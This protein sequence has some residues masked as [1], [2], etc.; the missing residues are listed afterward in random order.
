MNRRHFLKTTGIITVTLASGIG[1]YLS[2][3]PLKRKY[4][5]ENSLDAF[6]KKESILILNLK[7]MFDHSFKNNVKSLKPEMLL[8]TLKN[9]G[10]I[11]KDNQ[12]NIAKIKILAK[13]EPL[14]KYNGFYYSKTELELYSLA[15]S[16]GN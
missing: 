3:A 16:I 5:F 9:K 15:Y 6:K 8:E 2:Y 10:I 12:V 4:L 1:G 13:T 11:I 7:Y 14:I